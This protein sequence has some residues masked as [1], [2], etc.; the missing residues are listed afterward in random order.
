[1]GLFSPFCD[2]RLASSS[3]TGVHPWRSLDTCQPKR[4]CFGGGDEV[5]FPSPDTKV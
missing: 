3:D 2:G 1:M 5:S 4:V